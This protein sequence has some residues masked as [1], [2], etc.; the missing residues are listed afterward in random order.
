M[1]S[2][3][4]LDQRAGDRGHTE[5]SVRGLQTLAGGVAHDFNNVLTAVLGA[6]HLLRESPR[7]NDDDRANLHLIEDA[8]NRGAQITR[9]ILAYAGGG[10]AEVATFDLRDALADAVR[11]LLPRF[12]RGTS[13]RLSEPPAAVPVSGD[14]GQVSDA[15]L[16]VLENAREAVAEGGAID[17]SLDAGGG[18]AVLTV[19]DSGAGMEAATRERA[20]EPFF[21]T[22]PAATAAGLGLAATYGIATGH[23]GSIA[24]RSARGQGTTVTITLPET[25]R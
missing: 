8:A 14:R 7:L 25:D 23:R 13:L 10:P 4:E 22:K 1:T 16:N 19:G 17:V 18:R 15:I 9:E 11:L 3:A 6:C 5:T 21:T 20:F 2:G 24:L 12:R